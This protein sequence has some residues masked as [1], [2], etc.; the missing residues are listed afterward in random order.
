MTKEY[1]EI[2]NIKK[3]IKRKKFAIKCINILSLIGYY[4]FVGSLMIG[5][6]EKINEISSDTTWVNLMIYNFILLSFTYILF[7]VEIVNI[8]IKEIKKKIN[9]DKIYINKIKEA[10]HIDEKERFAELQKSVNK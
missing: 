7:Y 5:F 10:I 8:K 1:T 6:G 4:I 9:E 2:K 3:S